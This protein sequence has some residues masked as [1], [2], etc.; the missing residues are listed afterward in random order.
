MRLGRWLRQLLLPPW[1]ARLA[2]SRRTLAAIEEA[3]ARAEPSHDGRIRFAIETASPS[4][5]L[6][7]RV[8]ARTRAL[9]VFSTLRVW[10]TERNNGV[11][12]YLSWAE[13]AIEIVADRGLADRVR[14][15]EWQAV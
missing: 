2:A 8:C 1:W 6:L 4:A 12:I 14:Q 15:S 10:D 3:I 9:E 13:R 11:L 5:C 7:R